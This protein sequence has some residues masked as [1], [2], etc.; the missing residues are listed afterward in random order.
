[1]WKFLLVCVPLLQGTAGY[2]QNLA[3]KLLYSVSNRGVDSIYALERDGRTTTYIAEGFR[4]RL[5]HNGRMLAFS[6][7]RSNPN[8]SYGASLYLRDLTL[9]R[10]SLVFN[11]GDYLDYYDF[12]PSDKKLLYSQTCAVYSV[13]TGGATRDYAT[14]GCNPCDCYSDDPVVRIQDSLV[15]YHNVHFG[16]YRMRANGDSSRAIPHTYPGD[17]Y[18]VFSLDGAWLAYTKNTPGRGY[19]V[20]NNLHKIRPSGADS[21][22]LTRLSATDTIVPDPVWAADGASLYILA[23]IGGQSGLYRVQASGSGNPTLL[24]PF[25]NAL[26][27]WR[28]TLGLADSI[29]TQYVASVAS[30]A[31]ADFEMAPN[32]AGDVVTLRYAPATRPQIEVYDALGRLCMTETGAPAGARLHLATLP[33]GSYQIRVR[34]EG[35]VRVRR[36]ILQ[37]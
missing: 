7:N 8:N 6:R 32:P 28:Y 26:S 25:P 30:S 15:A 33:P 12:L 11:Q 16:L 9:G 4:P 29:R 21:T 2:A 18:P 36:L 22:A 34:T 27:I 3:G 23:R 31:S 19:Y 35:G 24:K 5:S 20:Q 37:R 10:D 17:L 13:T 1:M 14:I